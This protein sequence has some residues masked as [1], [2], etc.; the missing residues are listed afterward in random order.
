MQHNHF[1][2]SLVRTHIFKI[3]WIVSNSHICSCQLV[4][5]T[6]SS[7]YELISQNSSTFF[8]SKD[9]H[10][11]WKSY[12]KDSISYIMSM[13]LWLLVR[14]C[15]CVGMC[16][17]VCVGMCVYVCVF[18]AYVCID[19][20]MYVGL[21]VIMWVYICESENIFCLIYQFSLI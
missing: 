15:V 10:I 1:Q 6:I 17:Y 20:C 18:C 13:R 11:I 14:V 4:S 12:R 8:K 21:I 5:R 7:Q 2:K 16:V 9:C 19:L 3:W